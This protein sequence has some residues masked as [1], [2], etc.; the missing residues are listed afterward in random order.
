MSELDALAA[1][2]VIIIVAIAGAYWYLRA[3]GQPHDDQARLRRHLTM[4]GLGGYAPADTPPAPPSDRLTPL[5]IAGR[6]EPDFLA[7][8][9]AAYEQIAAALASDRLAT[10]EHLLTDDLATEFQEFLAARRSRNETASLMFIGFRAVEVVDCG[11]IGATA[12]AEV[13][14]VTDLVSVV[15]D[16]KGNVI[17]GDP[18][19]VA[20]CSELWTFER[21]TEQKHATWQLAA[22]DSDE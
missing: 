13:R 1:L 12:W 16:C 2:N 9:S 5:R 14:F 20:G 18:R 10:I 19:R 21:D 11:K 3:A 17:E 7:Q 8:A 4:I 6:T 22:T 15:H